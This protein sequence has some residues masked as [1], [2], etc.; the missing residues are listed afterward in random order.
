MKTRVWVIPGFGGTE[1]WQVHGNGRRKLW[2]DVQSLL[3]GGQAHALTLPTPPDV[4]TVVPG[5]LVSTLGYGYESL[6]QFLGQTL[7]SDWQVFSWPYDWRLDALTLGGQLAAAIQAQPTVPGGDRIIAHS[8]GALVASAAFA[9]LKGLGLA[10]RVPRIVT[11]AGILAGSYSVVKTWRLEEDSINML[12]AVG[13][14]SPFRVASSGVGFGNTLGAKLQFL[15]CF[16]SW[17]STYDMLPD[18]TGAD[19]PGDTNRA[20]VWDAGNWTQALIPPNAT[21]LQA[22]KGG[23]HTVA[24]DPAWWPPPGVLVCCVGTGQDTPNRLLA[25]PPHVPSTAQIMARYPALTREH[26]ANFHLPSVQ[27]YQRGD[28]RASFASQFKP[29]C[30]LLVVTGAHASLQNHP[31]IWANLMGLLSGAGSPGGLVSVDS[32]YPFPDTRMPPRGPLFRERGASANQGLGGVVS[33]APP[34]AH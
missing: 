33:I 2:I 12:G 34:V 6:L 20:L 29:G 8:Y 25:V 18:P 28:N 23:F 31:T 22:S 14:L 32:G 26:V 9:N 19:D 13:A 27:N 3:L 7:P 1:L 16:N 15:Q 17:P 21:L 24:A 5:G 11:I 10:A 4:G 30:Q